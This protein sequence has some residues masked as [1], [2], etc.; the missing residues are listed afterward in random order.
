MRKLLYLLAF[1]VLSV[2]CKKNAA[3]GS[4][5]EF[6][7][8]ES[9]TVVD[10]KC[11]VDPAGAVLKATPFIHNADIISYA[12][13]NSTYTLSSDAI[14][15][16]KTMVGR[17]PFAATVNGEVIFYGFYNPYILSSFCAHSISLDV[18]SEGTNNK[19][20]LRLGYPGMLS[21]VTIDDSRNDTRLI[22]VQ[23][24]QGKWRP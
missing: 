16:I 8:L 15:R 23:K 4:N 6:Y 18:D 21:G 10:G 11:Q 14:E 19:I 24:E 9:Y 13:F 3:I 7:G 2:S 22:D 20:V 17:Q 12:E 1:S 5:I